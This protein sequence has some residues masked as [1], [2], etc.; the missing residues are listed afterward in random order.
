[1]VRGLKGSGGFIVKEQPKEY[2]KA[3]YAKNRSYILAKA[4]ERYKYNA[5]KYRRRTRLNYKNKI[6]KQA[7]IYKEAKENYKNNV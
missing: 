7:L 4:K 6:A 2:F 3:Y 1:M 5:E